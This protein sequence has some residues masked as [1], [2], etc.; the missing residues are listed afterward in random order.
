MGDSGSSIFKT[1]AEIV[2][3][4]LVI[5]FVFGLIMLGINKGESVSTEINK[6]IDNMLETKYTKYVCYIFSL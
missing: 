2:G 5:G 3:A 4:L 1:I 6:S